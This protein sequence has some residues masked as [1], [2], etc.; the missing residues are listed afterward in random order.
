MASEV[1]AGELNLELYRADLGKLANKYIGETEK[2]LRRIFD[3]V[4]AVGIILL[5]DEADTLFG[6][7]TRER[8]NHDRYTN[9]GK[10]I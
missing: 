4:E 10:L 3:A 2:N 9:S 8:D 5:F 1:L 7:R 6:K